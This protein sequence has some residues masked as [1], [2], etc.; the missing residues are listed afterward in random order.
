MTRIAGVPPVEQILAG[1]LREGRGYAIRRPRGVDHW[2]LI[3]TI[4]GWGRQAVPGGA[5]DLRPGDAL[6]VAP[7]TPHEY[8]VQPERP[9]WELLFAHF[10][11][12]PEWLAWFDWPL[13]APGVAVMSLTG[14]VR[15]RAERA[16]HD[17]V[18]AANGAVR[19][20]Q[21]FSMNALET[22]LLWCDV[23]NP[24]GH[25]LD[26]RV[27]WCVEHLE[28]HLHETFTVSLLAQRVA[29]SPSRLAHLF[30]E[31]VGTSIGRYVLD[32]RILRAQQLLDLTSRPIAAI[33]RDVGFDD[34]LYFS[35]RF[36]RHVGAP[37]S[38]YR[39]RS[40][41]PPARHP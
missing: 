24:G 19:L 6:L 39:A 9:R 40:V 16:L 34:P 38:T 4:D 18:A 3:H 13:V 20:S 26:Q 1:R 12:R 2:L 15:E 23:Q 21:Q 31:Q 22:A 7:G 8:G 28:S 25:R 10:R 17:A 37:P 35:T 36:R 30:R 27:L 11:P 5:V 14:V 41:A 33:A 32:R 29:L